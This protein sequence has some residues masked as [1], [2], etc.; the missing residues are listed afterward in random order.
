VWLTLPCLCSAL[1]LCPVCPVLYVLSPV[2]CVLS[3]VSCASCVSCVSCVSCPSCVSCVSC[4]WCVSRRYLEGSLYCVFVLAPL[5]LLLSPGKTL[6]R[7]L[8][9]ANRYA[10]V[11]DGKKTAVFWGRCSINMK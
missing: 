4:L 5:M 6:F 7:H 8:T 10:P 11:A 9:E 1:V 3:P 2:S